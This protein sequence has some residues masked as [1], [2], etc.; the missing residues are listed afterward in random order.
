MRKQ[1]LEYSYKQGLAHIPSAL[2]MV[3]YLHSVFKYIKK[4]DKIIIGKPFGSQSYYLVWKNRGWLSNIDNL[5]MGVKHSEIPF[6]DY[7]EETIGNALGVA[8][9]IAMTTNKKVYVNITDASLQMGNTLEAV[10]FIGQHQ[11][12]NIVCTVDY[13]NF[14]VTGKTSDIINVEPVLTMAR[15]YNWNLF[16][17]DGHDPKKLDKIMQQAVQNSEQPS[18]VVCITKKGKGVKPMEEDPKG[19]HYRKL[20]ETNFTQIFNSVK[21]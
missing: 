14:Q 16:V 13:N 10:Q 18:M 5:H 20:D 15:L 3:D 21:E 7:S 11:Q 4:D 12:K 9:G 2:S 19:W 1:L 8:S 17:V 6:V